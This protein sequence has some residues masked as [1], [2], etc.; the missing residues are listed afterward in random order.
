MNP[1]Y[2]ERVTAMIQAMRIAPQS[3]AA[4]ALFSGLN[5][6][7]VLQWVKSWRDHKLVHVAGWENDARGYPTIQVMAWAP[8]AEDVPCPAMTVVQRN[9]R[10]RDKQ[11]KAD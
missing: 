7:T 3:Y 9:K 4:L 2:H 8:G 1:S 6:A 10:W 11:K 5:S